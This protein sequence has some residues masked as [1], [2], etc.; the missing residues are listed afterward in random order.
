MTDELVRA[1]LIEDDATDRR[2]AKRLSTLGLDCVALEPPAHLEA[3]GRMVQDALAGVERPLVLMDYRLDDVIQEYGSRAPYRGGTAAAHIR[4]FLPS[5]PLVLLTTETRWHK[6]VEGNPSLEGLFDYIVLKEEVST[7]ASRKTAVRRLTSIA[8]GFAE[9]REKWPK[10]DHFDWETLSSLLAGLEADAVRSQLGPS[11]LPKSPHSAASWLL[12]TV[13]AV[14]G[15]VVGS[16]E[17]AAMLG[18]ERPSFER[19]VVRDLLEPA[20][21]RGVFADTDSRWWRTSLLAMVRDFKRDEE[22]GGAARGIAEA[23]GADLRTVR[24]A[25]CVWCGET[26]VERVCSICGESVGRGHS[27]PVEDPN[28]PNWALPDVACFVCIESGRADDYD[29]G[30]AYSR[31]VEEVRSGEARRIGE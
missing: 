2:V 4:E 16:G 25:R 5:V 26:H 19:D 30:P 22:D 18:I 31:V 6:W 12:N 9:V 21:Y 8:Q 1:V 13:L 23:V 10:S 7:R 15:I 20:R 17:A 24:R 11:S 3:L 14:P 27:I 28:R 29:L